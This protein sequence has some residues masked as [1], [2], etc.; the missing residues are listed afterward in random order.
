MVHYLFA[1]YVFQCFGEDR[2]E[3]DGTVVFGTVSIPLLEY[4]GDIGFEPISGNLA[5]TQGPLE[6]VGDCWCYVYG[7]VL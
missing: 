2:C 7:T 5:G 3:G 4:T 6:Y 1:H